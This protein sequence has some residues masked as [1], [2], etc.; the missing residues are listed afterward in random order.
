MDFRILGPVE[1][2]QAET[3]IPINAAMQRAVLAVLLAKPGTAVS[4]D[5]IVDQLWGSNPPD[6]AAVTVRN[7][8]QRLRKR[9]PEQVLET[10]APG[11]R[12]NIRPEAVD[13]HRFS[14]LSEQARGLI[15]ENPAKAAELFASA[16][17]LWRGSPLADLGD[18]PV[19]ILQAPKLEELYL[20]TLEDRYE[21]ALLLG[22]S[23]QIVPALAD[24]TD[25][26]PYR[27]RLHRQLMQAL[28][29][30][31]RGSEAVECYRKLRRALVDELGVEP[32]SELRE[33]I[34]AITDNAAEPATPRAT[35][36]KPGPAPKPVELPPPI[37]TFVGRQD[38]LAEL[39]E[40]FTRTEHGGPP[41][42]FVHGP[43]GAGKSTLVGQFAHEHA[44]QYPDGILYVD[45]GGSSPNA[46]TLNA[47]EV[48]ATLLRSLGA[49]DTPTDD[50]L[51]TVRAYRA[52]LRGRRILIILDNAAHIS[53][54]STALPDEP[55]C[56][57]IVTSR[58]ALVGPSGSLHLHVDALSDT[59]AVDLLGQVAGQRR[60]VGEASTA[61]KLA[62]LCGNLPLALRIVATRTAMRPH[63]PLSTWVELLADEHR[64]LDELR[65]SDIDLR[66]S[67][68]VSIE[69]LRGDTEPSSQDA[70]EL[71]ASLGLLGVGSYT[72]PFAASLIGWP[73]E[74]TAV[75][76][77]NLVDAQLLYSTAPGTYR[78]YD[79]ISL[80][81]KE[82]AGRLPETA[83]VEALYA[84]CRWYAGAARQT[85][86]AV[87]GTLAPRGHPSQHHSV[88]ELNTLRFADKQ[89]ARRWLDTEFSNII[90][91]FRQA[92]DADVPG[93][94][95]LLVILLHSAAWYFNTLR[96]WS[97]RYE[98]AGLAIELGQRT[99]NRLAE[100]L[101]LAAIATVH[102]QQ[103]DFELANRFSR[104][105]LELLDDPRSFE[106]QSVHLNLAVITVFSASL[107]QASE[108]CNRVVDAARRYGFPEIEISALSNLGRIRTLQQ[109]PHEAIAILNEVLRMSR[110]LDYHQGTANA[111]NSLME[112][113]AQLGDHLE[114]VRYSAEAL[115]T[116]R[117]LN[118]PFDTADCLVT[119]SAALHRL[120]DTRQAQSAFEQAREHLAEITT[121]EQVQLKVL[122]DQFIEVELP[123]FGRA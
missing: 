11:Y 58:N 26:Y 69:Q 105:A 111:L 109:H 121:R 81:A 3:Q 76:L 55:T 106:H 85:N 72:A 34:K 43:G 44:D 73:A 29:R 104:Q 42:C 108:H 20:Y 30:A 6:S 114:V 49:G 53:Q 66:A 7:Y 39:R 71:F 8:V 101:G 16:L 96:R 54:L 75:A 80:L 102:A 1:V 117:K 57:A 90:P 52:R 103:N 10:A 74:R 9:L 82:Q 93:I 98:L 99:G 86:R 119:L 120:G 32:G 46:P 62:E 56:A 25:K 60:I 21:V 37:A 40:H 78:M 68:L 122:L 2:W 15:R 88:D 33:L 41:V 64:R 23:M 83:R 87:N 123:D 95:E 45:L 67:F 13:A 5:T 89:Q 14:T 36:T 38:E 48:L 4:M 110:A 115:E 28:Y 84:A 79:L 51:A 118:S 18:V 92:T 61:A 35:E 24:L 100:G 97:E 47:T 112:V 63:W 50:P 31:G 113:H 12:L 59:D 27:E 94:A 107:E 70:A 91:L 77:E 116:H 19:R 65:T 17:R 22:E